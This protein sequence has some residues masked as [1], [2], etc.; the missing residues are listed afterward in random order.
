MI[1]KKKQENYRR[2]LLVTHQFMWIIAFNIK[3]LGSRAWN[4]IQSTD[5]YRKDCP[6]ST[7]GYATI[8]AE[9]YTS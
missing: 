4:I 6:S 3:F 8:T 1:G 9:Y 2:E 5:M 7:F